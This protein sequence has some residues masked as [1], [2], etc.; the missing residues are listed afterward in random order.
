MNTLE[1]HAQINGYIGSIGT[2]MQILGNSFKT[3][4]PRTALDDACI[5]TLTL[6]AQALLAKAAELKAIQ[7]TGPDA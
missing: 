1:L 2:A 7:Y 6:Q 5:D 3:I 4:A